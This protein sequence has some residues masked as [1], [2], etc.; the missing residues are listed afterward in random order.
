MRKRI[1]VVGCCVSLAASGAH[2]QLTSASQQV[3]TV[4]QRDDL[5][6]AAQVPAGTNG[7][8]ELY[9]GESDDVGPQSVLEVKPRHP[10]VEAFADAQYFHTDN[11]FLASHDRQGADVLVSTV[12]ATL[13][14][15][16][17]TLAGGELSPSVGV[18]QQWFNYD[19]AGSDTVNVLSPNGFG[20]KRAGLDTFD[21]SAFTAF[22][23]LTWRRENW[24]VDAG[25][26]YQQ[27]QDSSTYDEFYHEYVPHW[28]LRRDISLSH[29]TALSVSYEG[30]Y[31]F[32]DTAAT[33][34]ATYPANYND[35]TD[36]SLVLVGSWR[37]CRL[38]IVQPFY[39]LEYSHYTEID[40][41]DL[42]NS[43]G[44]AWYCPITANV[45]VR[46]FAGYD[47]LNTDGYLAQNYDK[48][49]LGGGLN[50]S[51]RF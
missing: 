17:T 12:Q 35:R 26:D 14:P 21:F 28:S 20:V 1:Y 23:G 44:V 7:V 43:F 29:A 11:M 22:A 47:V 42:L 33:P 51:V 13:T 4:Q 50:L 27:L 34:A 30:D 40:R 36:Q 46:A 15:G 37:I 39:R 49:D 38:A 10:W 9:Q 41:D 8:P 32:T 19:L 45:S 31:R 5:Q 18:Q 2:A 48:L 3:D 24:V 16:S 25:F 6:Q